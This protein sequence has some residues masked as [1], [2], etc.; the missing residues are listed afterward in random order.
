[1]SNTFIC[2]KFYEKRLVGQSLSALIAATL[3][4]L[5]ACRRSHSLT[6]AVYFTSLSLFGLIS[7]FHNTFSCIWFFLFR[8]LGSS[9]LYR[10]K[11]AYTHDNFFI[12]SQK[13][14]LR[15]AILTV[16]SFSFLRFAENFTLTRLYERA[17]SNIGCPFRLHFPR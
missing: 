6:E 13:R 9:R 4:H 15:Q 5:S 12:I 8:F 16:F 11:T 17:K 1:M 10:L 7:S 3:Q 14:K 2:F